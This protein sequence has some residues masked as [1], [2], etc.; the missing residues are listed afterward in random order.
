MNLTRASFSTKAR[1]WLL[2]AGLTALFI[3]IGAGHR[4]CLPLVLR[5][6]LGGDELRRLLDVGQVRDQGLRA[7]RRSPSPRQPD[8]HRLV[9]ELAQLYGVPKP[10]VYMIPNEQP[11][12]FA[13]GRNPEHAAVAVTQGLL[14]YLPRD[15]VKGVLAHEFAH[16]KNRDIL[17][18]SIAAMIAGA[19]SA[20]GNIFFWTSLFGGDD[21]DNPLGAIGALVMIL[22]APMAAMLLQL[23]VSRQREYLADATAARMLGTGEPSPRRWR[24]S[25]A[26][27]RRCRCRSTR[28]RRRCTSSTRCG[29]WAFAGALP[30]PPADRRPIG[31]WARSQPR[32]VATRGTFPRDP[33]SSLRSHLPRSV[34]AGV[35][36]PPCRSRRRSAR[37]SSTAENRGWRRPRTRSTPRSTSS[38]RGPSASC[39]SASGRST[40]TGCIRTSASSSPSS[41]RCCSTATCL[42][43]GASSTRSPAPGPRWCSRSRAATT[44]PA[45]TSPPSTACSCASRRRATTSSCSSP[46]CATRSRGSRPWTVRYRDCPLALA[47]SASGSR[48]RPPPSYS[49]FGR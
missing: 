49:P 3:G 43:A 25:S 35:P 17:V 36:R 33:S 26:A 12:A 7:R 8:L 9:A 32:L 31:A 46:S 1:T 19:I 13:T 47:T 6:L 5:R 24:R 20:I 41:S 39:P 30:D 44:R 37:T 4:R 18:S 10:R 34:S 42:A 38:S 15:Q 45:S 23:A 16:I 27:A 29:A 28:R 2:L 48:R 40:S 11:N 21:N 22:V 14:Q